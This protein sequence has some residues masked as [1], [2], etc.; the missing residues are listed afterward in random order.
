YRWQIEDPS[1][2]EGFTPLNN[3]PFIRNQRL[4]ATFAGVDTEA[5]TITDLA[6]WNLHAWTNGERGRIR[7]AEIRN[8]VASISQPV[9]IAVCITDIDCSGSVDGDDVILF[10][11]AWD[12]GDP[13][14]DLTGDGGVDGDDVIEFFTRWDAGC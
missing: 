4:I 9:E 3:G 11:A 7:C 1:S 14:A 6:G 5:V 10:F 8:G 13:S 12:F 2:P